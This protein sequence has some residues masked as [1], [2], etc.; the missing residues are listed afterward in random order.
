MNEYS[1]DHGVHHLEHD[2]PGNLSSD[3]WQEDVK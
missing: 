1:H 3:C 2:L